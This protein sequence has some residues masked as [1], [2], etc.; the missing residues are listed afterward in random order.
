MF[1][2]VLLLRQPQN[3]YECIQV[4]LL[5]GV[6]GYERVIGKGKSV[7]EGFVKALPARSLFL[8]GAHLLSLVLTAIWVL[9]TIHTANYKEGRYYAQMLLFD[10]YI[11]HAQQV[12]TPLR[13]AT[14]T[15]RLLAE[16][17]WMYKPLDYRHD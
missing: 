11:P 6:P 5:L 8:A 10:M 14:Q 3:D 1:P 15:A 13:P 4:T 17:R 9:T 16:C 12:C 2:H 7:A